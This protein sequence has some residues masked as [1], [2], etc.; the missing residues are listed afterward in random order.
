MELYNKYRPKTFEEMAGNDLAIKTV[1]GCLDNG[2][3]TF[4]FTGN[5]GCGKSSLAGCVANYL[6][7]SELSV[8]EIN[9]SSDRGIDNM[10]AI[11]E[12]IR[13]APINGEKVVYILDECHSITGPAQE[14]LLRIVEECPSWVYF[15][16]CTT[17][18]EKLI[19]T[20][21][22]RCSEI[23]LK[24]LDNTTMFM[25]LRRIAHK[26]GVVVSLDVLHKIA[27]MTDGSSRNAIQLLSEVMIL[28]NDEE[29]NKYL[30]E[31][32]LSDE[33]PEVIELCRA[34]LS[35]KGY[36]VYMQCLEKLKNELSSNAEGIRQAIMGYAY[37]VL[38]KSPNEAAIGMIQV[39]GNT[40]CY[41]NGKF[42][43]MIA[44]LDF[45]NYMQS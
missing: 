38:K 41:K 27:D 8:R 19:D 37:A 10:R 36:E 43:I 4:L 17:N 31:K 9:A 24:P 18:P 3:Q 5:K 2:K 6:G 13:Y 30:S 11:A 14:S 26:E 35:Q 22:S 21:R 32:I 15:I 25:Q 1:K 44:I 23:N 34:L 33:K 20:L 29:R 40:D 28:D 39:F 12:E 16:F 42:G 45:I 7:C